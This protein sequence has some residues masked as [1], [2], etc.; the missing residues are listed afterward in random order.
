MGSLIK[1]I[2]Q[3]ERPRERVL[4]YGI[5]KVSNEELI[6]II[7]STGSKNISVKEL[8]LKVLELINNIKEM[9]DLTVNKLCEIKG[10]KQAKAISL[11]ASI[12]LGKRVYLSG[13]EKIKKFDNTVKVYKYFKNIFIHETQEKFYVLYLNSKKELIKSALLFKGTLNYSTV[14]P[15]EI[16]KYAFLYS[17]SSMIIVHNHPSGNSRPSLSDDDI[18]KK[19]FKIGDFIG[20]KVIDHVIIGN[21]NYYSYY[22]QE[23]DHEKQEK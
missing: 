19:L 23:H 12:E 20:I 16:F 15:R 9:S 13:N 4:K 18:T 7:L 22:E 8:S 2:P 6:S 17:A 10:I 14:H 3:S 1:D 21:N 5:E 11:L